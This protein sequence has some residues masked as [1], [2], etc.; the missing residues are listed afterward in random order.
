VE[1][2]QTVHARKPTVL[3]YNIY[4][5]PDIVNLEEI[6]VEEFVKRVTTLR[7]GYT[8]FEAEILQDKDYDLRAESMEYDLPTAKSAEEIINKEDPYTSDTQ[9]WE[10]TPFDEFK[11]IGPYLSRFHS[12]SKLIEKYVNL[13]G[14]WHAGIFIEALSEE[15]LINH[16]RSL[17]LVNM[18][19]DGEVYYR[20]QEPRKLAGI[21]KA[22]DSTERLIELLGPIKTIMW[23]QNC[24]ADTK[25]FQ[26][27]NP[28]P[29]VI[30]NNM[31]W[32]SFTQS[33]KDNIDKAETTW[34]K[35]SIISTVLNNIEKDAPHVH[36]LKKYKSEEIERILENGYKAAY[37][38]NIRSE[39]G[40]RFFLIN[41]LFYPEI[42]NSKDASRI[43]N[44]DLWLE[45]KKINL[46]KNML[47]THKKYIKEGKNNVGS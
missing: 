15:S 44:Q 2:K 36:H 26:I 39:K 23:Q 4:K 35:R 32:F 42:M 47:E 3:A 27:N 16:L 19:N 14:N 13:W 17:L 25:Y 5:E 10:D 30:E 9:I 22:L 34:Y 28:K 45:S 38:K 1:E 43:A 29:Q 6:S 21:L 12:D 33:E 24:G 20:L 40:L 41:T 37:K 18:P 11:N 8:L 31:G 7:E 46:L